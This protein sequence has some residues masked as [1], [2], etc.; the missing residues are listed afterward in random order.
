MNLVLVEIGEIK[1]LVLE[2]ATIMLA[3]AESE[4]VL[5]SE[6][7]FFVRFSNASEDEGGDG[8]GDSLGR[9]IISSRSLPHKIMRL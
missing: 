1:G 6:S 9:A 3:M 2:D 8:D 7:V 5:F 4:R